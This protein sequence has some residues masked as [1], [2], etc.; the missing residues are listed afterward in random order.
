M[1]AKQISGDAQKAPLLE[2]IARKTFRASEIVN[3]LLNF[4]RTSPIEFVPLDLNKIVRE[5]LTLVE[6]QFATA[7]IQ[8]ELALEETLPRIRGNPGKLQQVFLNLFL[9]AR[10]AMESGGRLTVTTSRGGS[11]RRSV[12]V[13]VGDTGTGIAPENL[14]RLFDPFF[15]TKGA[16]KGTGLGLSV[17]Y[18]IVR[19][20]GGEI[21][22][23]S[24]LGK[25]AR[26][27]LSFPELAFPEVIVP[28]AVRLEPVRIE[29]SLAAAAIAT[30]AIATTGISA[31]ASVP[32]MQAAESDRVTQ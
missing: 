9:N 10:D 8:V 11:G 16:R 22:V 31:T 17:S 18:G 1:L 13:S 21:E 20:H 14:A 12:R 6:H 29:S 25:G 23:E 5:T 27:G 19:E 28:E 15:T 4:S 7:G 3:S 24:E 32:A 26:F 30:A 2:K